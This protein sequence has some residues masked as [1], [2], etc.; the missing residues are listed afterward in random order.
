MTR[1]TRNELREQVG[2]VVE[3]L[4]SHDPESI[5]DDLSA[6]IEMAGPSR[7]RADEIVTIV[8]LFAEMLLEPAPSDSSTTENG[9]GG[10]LLGSA[11]LLRE[12]MEDGHRQRGTE[13]SCF[14]GSALLALATHFTG[15]TS[16]VRA[17]ALGATKVTIDAALEVLSWSTSANPAERLVAALSAP[18]A[19]LVTPL[20]D[21]P[22]RLVRAAAALNR[23]VP[24][25]S[26]ELHRQRELDATED[27]RPRATGISS[28]VQLS[29][30]FQRT[31]LAVPHVARRFAQ[32][33][34]LS[35]FHEWHVASKPFPAAFDDYI[36]DA[37]LHTLL[38]PVPEQFAISHAGHG[39]NSFG[40]NLRLALG[41]V[42]MQLQVG[43]G[44]AFGG[45][46]D[47]ERWAGL[48][49]GVDLVTAGIRLI[50][51]DRLQRR[52]WLVAHSDFRH[53]GL[54]R[55]LHLKDDVWT[56][57]DDFHDHTLPEHGHPSIEAIGRR[58]VQIHNVI[59]QDL[60]IHERDWDAYR[61]ADG[62][63]LTITPIDPA[64][65]Y[66]PA[67]LI[68]I[69]VDDVVVRLE[70]SGD[71][72]LQVRRH[73]VWARVEDAEASDAAQPGRLSV[74]RTEVQRTPIAPAAVPLFD[75][76]ERIGLRLPVSHLVPQ[77]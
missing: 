17:D 31:G 16:H 2:H 42:A 10:D 39:I 47:A 18:D 74:V 7:I 63:V 50:G 13:V 56:E 62:E 48:V 55:L 75:A 5:A 40:L 67:D 24:S 8:E 15:C 20:L 77:A 72:D 59:E 44:G 27:D 34:R 52:R 3:V 60:L 9:D 73:G 22:D 36:F 64:D 30:T 68:A 58:W 28:F 35:V 1:M 69:S 12:T 66:D 21:D 25:G 57:W 37:P 54:P 51:D 46:E 29:R 4:M 23:T 70:Y 32:Q 71:D 61:A 33:R 76:A 41:P 49:D 26:T 38:G 11:R 43:W 65:P 6:L 14:L 19:R 53:G 45:P